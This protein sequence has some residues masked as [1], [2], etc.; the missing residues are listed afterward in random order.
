[1]STKES[2]MIRAQTVSERIIEEVTSWPGVTG[3]LG[4]RGEFSLKLGNREIGHLHGDHAAHFHFP[5]PVWVELREQGRIVPHPV[6]PQKRGPAARRIENEADLRDVVELL[7][8]NYEDVI[9]REG[10]PTQAPEA[11]RALAG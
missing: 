11:T 9:A 1:M 3:G 10:L 6:F 2:Q 5:P 8:L 7:R 4:R